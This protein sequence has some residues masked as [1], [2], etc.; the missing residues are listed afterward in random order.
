MGTEAARAPF[1]SPDGRLL[2]FHKGGSGS[3][4]VASIAGSAPEML[5]EQTGVT[6]GDWGA[7]DMVYF[8]SFD[9]GISRVPASGGEAEVLTSPDTP[10]GEIIH[11][12]VDV[13]PGAKGA[14]R[15]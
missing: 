3:L 4:W 5:V 13:L 12:T 9:G 6:A 14:F 2:A 1:F 11:S 8:G 15:P 10:R 7:D